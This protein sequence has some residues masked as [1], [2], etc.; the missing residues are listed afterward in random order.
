MTPTPDEIQIARHALGERLAHVRKVAGLTQH[1]L[2][3]AI[4]ASRS[5]IAGIQTGRQNADRAFWTR[6]DQLTR[7]DGSLL[8]A[9]DHLRHLQSQPARR[10][11]HGGRTV[12]V[13]FVPYSG[14]RTGSPAASRA[15]MPRVRALLRTSRPRH[16]ERS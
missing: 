8:T 5:S 2:A 7:A 12:D 10:S 14:W 15:G 4:F 3:D 9:Y 16:R 6:A 11:G 1:Q 13:G